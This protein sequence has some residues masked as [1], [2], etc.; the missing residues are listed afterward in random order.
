MLPQ[1]EGP[2]GYTRRKPGAALRTL[3]RRSPPVQIRSRALSEGAERLSEGA[4]RICGR[5]RFCAEGAGSR[6]WF[7]S[8]PAHLRWSAVCWFS[9]WQKVNARR[10]LTELASGLRRCPVGRTDRD[11]INPV[12][13]GRAGFDER[14]IPRSS[15]QQGDPSTVPP[16]CAILKVCCD[17]SFGTVNG[18]PSPA[19]QIGSTTRRLHGDFGC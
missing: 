4:G 16:A 10:R 1:V 9:G 15:V 19:S 12:E 18:D 14:H 6:A 17:H 5:P 7:K 3:S 11:P 13:K 8:G 2:V